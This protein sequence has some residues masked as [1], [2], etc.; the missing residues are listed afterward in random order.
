MKTNS[1]YGYLKILLALHPNK[2]KFSTVCLTF[3]LHP[4]GLQNGRPPHLLHQPDADD[5]D[6]TANLPGQQQVIS[7]WT[8]PDHGQSILRTV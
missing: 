8:L 5:H 6:Q 7:H 3:D 1:L 2:Y 4:S